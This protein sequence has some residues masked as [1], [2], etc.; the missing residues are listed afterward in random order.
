MMVH[1]V[2]KHDEGEQLDTLGDRVRVI[3]ADRIVLLCGAA[4]L[5]AGNGSSLVLAGGAGSGTPRGKGR[6]ECDEEWETLENHR[7]NRCG[8]DPQ[9]HCDNNFLA[10]H[11]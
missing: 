8:E 3:E 1:T 6:D 10:V 9:E 7:R 2:V 4:V 5:K 11:V